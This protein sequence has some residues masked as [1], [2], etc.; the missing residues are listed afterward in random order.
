MIASPNFL[1]EDFHDRS[2]ITPE[3]NQAL[4]L[5]SMNKSCSQL[6]NADHACLRLKSNQRNQK[7]DSIF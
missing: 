2:E 1:Y 6:L 4:S 5:M 7:I 3:M